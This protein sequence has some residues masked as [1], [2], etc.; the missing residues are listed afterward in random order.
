MQSIIG[1]PKKTN[2]ERLDSFLHDGWLPA[3]LFLVLALSCGC[4]ISIFAPLGGGSDEPAHLY[5]I[6]QLSH[7]KL[8]S[9]W[10]VYAESYPT[11]TEKERQ[12][13]SLYG[14][15]VDTNLS[16]VALQGNDKMWN[17]NISN[18]IFTFPAWK[19][20]SNVI[21]A[22][23]GDDGVSTVI[24]SNTAINTPFA[25]LPQLLFYTIARLVTPS[26]TKII[27]ACRLGG[28]LFYALAIAWCIRR[29]PI[30]KWILA[31]A[32][33]LPSALGVITFT[34]A[35]TVAIA[36][37][38]IYTTLI[39]TFVFSENRLAR[40][41]WIA[42]VVASLYL[43][44]IKMTYFP[45][46]LL[47]ALIPITNPLYRNRNHALALS[48]VFI[49][50]SALFLAWYL[51]IHNINSCAVFLPDLDSSIKIQQIAAD[52]A[53]FLN[54]I[55]DNLFKP[56]ALL[57]MAGI[58]LGSIIFNES[59][60][61]PYWFI[62][63][64]ATVAVFALS[65]K[66]FQTLTSVKKSIIVLIGF[67]IVFTIILLLMYIAVYI[68]FTQ[69]SNTASIEGMQGRYF[70][71]I[72]PLFLI[73]AALLVGHLYKFGARNFTKAGIQPNAQETLPLFIRI[74]TAGTQTFV[75]LSLIVTVIVFT[76]GA[77]HRIYG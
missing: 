75:A 67:L 10:V 19:D 40:P 36:L 42:L 25:Y 68:S 61:V 1:R 31:F 71:P 59:I 35:D 15:G 30:G 50:S 43:A 13:A 45:L 53:H 27:I 74:T 29:I 6:D 56:P 11:D 62:Y 58:T 22:R 65:K 33:L 57:S 63:I 28:L 46:I 26:L 76:I 47:L 9:D 18:P 17:P 20:E 37:C 21:G 72:I 3:T 48:G 34:S 32:G 55:S 38:F 69:I 73:P 5:R 44:T 2:T 16:R 24:F 8:F 23:Y 60:S 12:L 14:G 54:M 39:M 51:A 70:I 66:E 4:Y 77:F 7:G 41:W 64:I 49:A 52:P